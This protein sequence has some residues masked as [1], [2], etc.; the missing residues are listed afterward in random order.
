M[1]V[2]D[3]CCYPRG[4]KYTPAPHAPTRERHAV[5]QQELA[6]YNAYFERLA[7]ELDPKGNLHQGTLI[8]HVR[9]YISR[10]AYDLA[11]QQLPPGERGQR[12]G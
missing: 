6:E 2:W 10:L 4:M 8:Y 1:D 3:N 5:I 7:K 11:M 12:K 9:D